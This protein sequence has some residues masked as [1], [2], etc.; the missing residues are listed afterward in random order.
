[1]AV[2]A[3]DAEP[4]NAPSPRASLG[5]WLPNSSDRAISTV[6]SLKHIDMQ[7]WTIQTEEAWRS[8]N[9]LGH[10]SCCR[11]DADRERLSTYDWMAS[12]MVTRLDRPTNGISLPIGAWYQYAGTNRKRP[13]L[14]RSG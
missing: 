10:L 6:M 11:N 4:G 7:L 1:M 14:R 2:K 5:Q 13:D 9:Q 12:P 3:I 8:L